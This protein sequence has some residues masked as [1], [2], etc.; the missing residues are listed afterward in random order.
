MKQIFILFLAA[1]LLGCQ[2]EQS[3]VVTRVGFL[4][5]Q[6]MQHP[7]LP[8]GQQ[9]QFYFDVGDEPGSMNQI[10][11]IYPAGMEIPTET[12]RRVEL[13]GIIESISFTDGK[14][15]D[16]GYSNEAL[17]LHKWRYLD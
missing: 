11:V 5:E 1:S 16:A 2:T 14:V 13:T 12:G 8:S 15:G 9:D 17:T 7:I 6:I 10:I 3:D 4:A